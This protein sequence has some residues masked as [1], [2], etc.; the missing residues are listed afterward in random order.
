MKGNEQ[1]CH[2]E[3]FTTIFLASHHRYRHTSHCDSTLQ[4]SCIC[5]TSCTLC[6]AS[7]IS[8]LCHST[9]EQISDWHTWTSNHLKQLLAHCYLSEKSHRPN[10]P[11]LSSTSHL[12]EA[13]MVIILPFLIW[14][15]RCWLHIAQS[16]CLSSRTTCL[17]FSICP[18][19]T[20][21]Q[22]PLNVNSVHWLHGGQI[23]PSSLCTIKIPASTFPRSRVYLS[24]ME[25]NL[26]ISKELAVHIGSSRA[27]KLSQGVPGSQCHG[28]A[29]GCLLFLRFPASRD[30]VAGCD[31]I[32]VAW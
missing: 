17:S 25:S 32:N 15:E 31:Y 14:G 24:T 29:Q 22:S 3:L 7:S 19:L 13:F 27:W 23:P 6:T 16:L 21:T 12:L 28:G 5:F 8:I 18:H 11:P 20:E 10:S 9:P 26:V 30:R 1:S 2:L 4:P